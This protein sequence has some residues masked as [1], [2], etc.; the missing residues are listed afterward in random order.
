MR[1]SFATEIA[2]ERFYDQMERYRNLNDSLDLPAAVLPLYLAALLF[3][4]DRLAAFYPPAWSWS[5]TVIAYLIFAT[6][7]VL[8]AV[9]VLWAGWGYCRTIWCYQDAIDLPSPKEM[10]DWL[11]AAA[12]G[13]PDPEELEAE[14]EPGLRQDYV[15][16][17]EATFQQNETRSRRMFYCRRHLVVSVVLTAVALICYYSVD[18]LLH[19]ESKNASQSTVTTA[20]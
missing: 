17:A 7:V 14:C 16:C 3:F 9:F 2:K 10:D 20:T 12:A 1:Q 8:L 5:R 19:M 6:L 4:V 13:I 15:A 18:R 11:L